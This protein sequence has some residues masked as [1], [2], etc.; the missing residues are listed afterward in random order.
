MRPKV[1]GMLGFKGEDIV[2]VKEG[3]AL[4]GSSVGESEEK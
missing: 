2:V 1:D 4:V 3:K